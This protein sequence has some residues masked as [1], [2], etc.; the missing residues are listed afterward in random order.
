MLI[1]THIANLS[2]YKKA[3]QVEN[4]IH[5]YLQNKEY[6]KLDLPV[7]SSSLIPEGYLEIFETE[8]RFLDKK[9]KLYLTP[10]PELF[11][12]RLLSQGVGDCYYLGKSFRNSEPNSPKHF[13]E[14]TMLE[15]YKV[16]AHYKDIAAEVLGML[17]AISNKLT[18]KNEIKYQGKTI[19]FDK[20]EEITITEVF[21]KYSN[22]TEEELFD[23]EK[24]LR[25]AKE[26]GYVIEG[27]TYED[28]F[29]QIYAQE[30]EHHLG[31]NG[32]PTILFDYPKEFAALSKPNSDGKTA[33]RFEFYIEGVELGNCYSELTDWQEQE[34]R[35]ENEATLRSESGKIR[36]PIDNGFIEALKHG[37]PDC[38][39]I[40]IGVE[41]LSMI[42]A[43]VTSIEE[44]KLITIQ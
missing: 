24:F 30:I 29:S 39:G 13:P 40:A 19:S 2:N 18:G 31:T 11:I 38:A 28:L 5:S 12:K 42:F 22:I 8:F 23:H 21:A 32:Y 36:H 44:L 14:F 33:Q 4:T 16:G 26:K 35:F 7:L 43:N 37:L 20:W 9:E 3:L 25:K 27:F 15:F 1:N 6:L 10:S 41:R 17:S 34:K